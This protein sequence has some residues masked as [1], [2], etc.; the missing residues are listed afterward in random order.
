MM[1][2]NFKY[3]RVYLASWKKYNLPFGS[4]MLINV[5]ENFTFQDTSIHSHDSENQTEVHHQAKKKT[6]ACDVLM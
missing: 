2:D 4:A 5:L 3:F 1:E 6:D